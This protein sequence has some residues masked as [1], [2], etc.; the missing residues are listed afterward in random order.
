MLFVSVTKFHDKFA[1]L[2][3]VLKQRQQPGQD[4]NMLYRHVFGT[5]S[6]D[7]RGILRFFFYFAGFRGFT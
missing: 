1:G 6:S 3:R 2:R 7:F 5:I 4:L